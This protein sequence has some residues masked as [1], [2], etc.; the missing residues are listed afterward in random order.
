MGRPAYALKKRKAEKAAALVKK[1]AAEKKASELA[2][3]AAT[4]LDAKKKKYAKE[5]AERKK[6]ISEVKQG[7]KKASGSR[8]SQSK[9]QSSQDTQARNTAAADARA[10]QDAARENAKKAVEARAKQKVVEKAAANKQKVTEKAAADKKEAQRISDVQAA[11]ADRD[12]ALSEKAATGV[13][14]GPP[15]DRADTT[16]DVTQTSDI[17]SA[18]QTAPENTK[19]NIVAADT[20]TEDRAKALTDFG[21]ANQEWQKAVKNKSDPDTIAALKQTSDDYRDTYKKATDD[22]KAVGTYVKEIQALDDTAALEKNQIDAITS[23]KDE[24]ILQAEQELLRKKE[25]D[26]AVKGQIA[27]EEAAQRTLF[28]DQQLAE[29]SGQEL[30]RSANALARQKDAITRTLDTETRS[31]NEQ[32]RQLA[33]EGVQLERAEGT[34]KRRGQIAAR[35]SDAAAAEIANRS[36]QSGFGGSSAALGAQAS[37]RS[38]AA[39]QAGDILTKLT[40][41]EAARVTLGEQGTL[42]G[43][44]FQDLQSG[45]SDSFENLG[46]QQSNLQANRFKL[47]TR[48]TDI[49]IEQENLRNTLS[50]NLD[51][52][53]DTFN[54]GGSISGANASI[55]AANA[56]QSKEDQR[57][58]AALSLG[59]SGIGLAA[60]GNPVLGGVLI[61]KA[62][63]DYFDF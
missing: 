45:I 3:K 25:K 59:V 36:A 4:E 50:S 37:A 53:Q 42:L 29:L 39:T 7:N 26:E 9:Q 33:A 49:G 22:E 21:K 17:L 20:T 48:M 6:T 30:D 13:N 61:V 54:L 34:V 40:D 60:T 15:A 57:K 10:R 35:S 1:Q 52:L 43:K 19:E 27:A 16:K 46:D 51:F 62:L 47:D 2:N 14:V 55:N 28:R 11:Q 24:K 18:V 31:F 56:A 5:V 32:Q 12:K 44:S 41:V 58:S 38:T 23:G 8:I 63:A